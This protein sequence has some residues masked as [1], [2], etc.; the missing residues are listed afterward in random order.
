MKNYVDS[1]ITYK[2][3]LMDSGIDPKPNEEWKTFAPK[4]GDVAHVDEDDSD[5]VFDGNNWVRIEK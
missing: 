2:V 3:L 5:Y 4:K 1:C